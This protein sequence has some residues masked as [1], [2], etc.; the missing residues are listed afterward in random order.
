MKIG[1]M[2]AVLG[3]F[4]VAACGGDLQAQEPSTPTQEETVV[5]VKYPNLPAMGSDVPVSVRRAFA[6]LQSFFTSL[7]A[8]DPDGVRGDVAS[9]IFQRDRG[10]DR[11]PA[12]IAPPT[13]ASD[14][15]AVDHTLNTDGSANLSLEWTWTDSEADIDG[16][17]VYVRGSTSNAAYTIGTTPAEEETF[18]LPADRRALIIRGVPADLH[19][20]FGVR[21]YRVVDLVIAPRGLIQSPVA[22]P[23]A[24]AENPYR[25]SSS[26]AFTGDITGTTAW[27]TLGALAALDTVNTPQIDAGALTSFVTES[28]LPFDT[29]PEN[30]SVVVLVDTESASKPIVVSGATDLIQVELSADVTGTIQAS[31]VGGYFQV[32]YTIYRKIDTGSWASIKSDSTWTHGQQTT[33]PLSIKMLIREKVN[34]VP[35]AAA[36]SSIYY[37]AEAKYIK[38]NLSS[39]TS[40][41]VQNRILDVTLHKKPL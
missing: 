31:S 14:G 40:Q 25:P 21:A 27:G 26:V 19:Y 1:R 6:E 35:G 24:A 29:L 41:S 10:N 9:V 7:K 3:L 22:Q 38:V 11:N 13:I 2:F 15:T 36:G 4:L 16:W 30:P 32:L 5:A 8:L 33:D 17:T 23:S 34:D 37:K 20:T 39:V 28:D 18:Q 12:A